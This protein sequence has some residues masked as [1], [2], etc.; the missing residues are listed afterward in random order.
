MW[1]DEAE[2]DRVADKTTNQSTKAWF[3]LSKVKRAA[4]GNSLIRQ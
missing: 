2:A 4:D 3:L 1:P